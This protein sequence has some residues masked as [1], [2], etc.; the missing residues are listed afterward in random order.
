M[1]INAATGSASVGTNVTA[2]LSGSGTLELAGAVSA[3]GTTTAANRVDVAM[4]DPTTTLLVSGGNQQVGGIDGSGT[5]QINAG[6][7]LTANHVTAG[8]LVIGGDAA[9]SATLTI[10]ASATDGSPLASGGFALAGSLTAGASPGDAAA[11][12]SSLMGGAA[13]SIGGASLGGSSAAGAGLGAGVAAVPEPSAI[14]LL[15]LGLL[16]CLLVA[17]GRRGSRS[18][19]PNDNPRAT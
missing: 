15:A 8:A 7:S 11:G 12:S 14:V 1:R 3:L 2:N 16:C 17:V 10:A 5:V 18:A 9:N 19:L 4:N 6:T 13:A